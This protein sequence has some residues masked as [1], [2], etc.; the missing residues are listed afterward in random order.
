MPLSTVLDHLVS[1]GCTLPATNSASH[2]TARR[3]RPWLVPA[4]SARGRWQ[5]SRRLFVAVSLLHHRHVAPSITR[6]IAGCFRFFTLIQCLAIC[7]HRENQRLVVEDIAGDAVSRPVECE[8]DR[9]LA[10]VATTA[11]RATI[12]NPVILR[13]LVM[14]TPPSSKKKWHTC[15]NNKCALSEIERQW[16]RPVRRISEGSGWIGFVEIFSKRTNIP[17]PSRRAPTL[18]CPKSTALHFD[19]RT[20]SKKYRWLQ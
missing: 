3:S 15:T 19:S 12:T 2:Q 20:L 17:V 16:A 11:S 18:L 8:C 4:Q 14:G 10:V 7:P 5:T 13:C 6:L 9:T 1:I